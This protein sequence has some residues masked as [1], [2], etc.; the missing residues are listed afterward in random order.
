MSSIN[1]FLELVCAASS[2]QSPRNSFERPGTAP[3][4]KNA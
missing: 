3:A 4:P 1:G 2:D